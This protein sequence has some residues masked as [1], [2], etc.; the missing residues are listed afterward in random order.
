MALDLRDTKEEDKVRRQLFVI[1]RDLVGVCLES[2]LDGANDKELV[3]V[4]CDVGFAGV[5]G[6][7]EIFFFSSLILRMVFA[8]VVLPSVRT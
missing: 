6:D 3:N 8:N 4:W 2:S 1:C 7:G 5:V